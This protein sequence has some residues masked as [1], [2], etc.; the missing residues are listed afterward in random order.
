MPTTFTTHQNTFFASR[1]QFRRVITTFTSQLPFLADYLCISIKFPFIGLPFLRFFISLPHVNH[2]FVGLL[3]FHCPYIN[4]T[5]VGLSLLH[6]PTL[7]AVPSDHCRFA[8][9]PSD[10]LTVLRINPGGRLQ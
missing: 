6:N 5:F 9:R 3:P 4:S 7:G 1:L 2:R 8:A 10:L